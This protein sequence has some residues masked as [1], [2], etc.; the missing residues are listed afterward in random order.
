LSAASAARGG[1]SNVA[2][3]FAMPVSGQKPTRNRQA[4]IN[5][6]FCALIAQGPCV[7]AK[8][9]TEYV[10]L[11]SRSQVCAYGRLNNRGQPVEVR[12]AGIYPLDN[13]RPRFR[14]GDPVRGIGPRP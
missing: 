5:P 3:F 2:R 6:P 4:R 7:R 11:V 8:I 13:G 10:D 14:I 9:E 1:I 12:H